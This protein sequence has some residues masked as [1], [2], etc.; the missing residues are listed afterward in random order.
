M[1]TSYT[2]NT[3]DL[4]IALLPTNTALIPLLTA[5]ESHF[6]VNLNLSFFFSIM[7][8]MIQYAMH[9]GFSQVTVL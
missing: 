2:V 5:D 1:V 3:S 4:Q 9:S 8:K 7:V 6:P